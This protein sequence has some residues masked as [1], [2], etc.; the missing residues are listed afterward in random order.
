[1]D[2][3]STS[4]R[5]SRPGLTFYYMGRPAS[6]YVQTMATI[7]IPNPMSSGGSIGRKAAR[8]GLELYPQAVGHDRDSPVATNDRQQVE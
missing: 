4:S 8:T 2:N 7:P 5:A 3:H 1:M 6:L